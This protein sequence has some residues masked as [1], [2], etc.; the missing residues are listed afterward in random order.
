MSTIA[1]STRWLRGEI[2][3]PEPGRRSWPGAQLANQP[4]LLPRREH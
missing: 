2:E 1:Q 3:G 4:G